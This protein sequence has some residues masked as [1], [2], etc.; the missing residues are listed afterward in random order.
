[1]IIDFHIASESA[2][3]RDVTWHW[4][5]YFELPFGIWILLSIMW[6]ARWQVGIS[7]ENKGP[8]FTFYIPISQISIWR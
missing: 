2:K 6:P 4:D 7:L 8:Y 5:K 3:E 1:M